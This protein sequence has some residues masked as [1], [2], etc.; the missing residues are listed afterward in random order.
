LV[1]D[2]PLEAEFE[3]LRLF[4]RRLGDF[5]PWRGDLVFSPTGEPLGFMVNRDY[6]AM[7]GGFHPQQTIRPGPDIR[8]QYTRTILDRL[9]ARVRALPIKTQ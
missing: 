2:F 5:A 4:K 7:N 3:R 6:G 9:V 1:S 8:N